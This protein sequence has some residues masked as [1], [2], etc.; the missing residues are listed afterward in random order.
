M[1]LR[2][3]QYFIQLCKDRNITKA[4][5]NLYISQQGLSK[6]I[7]RLEEEL[8]FP[9]FE[10]SASGVVPTE[11]ANYLYDYFYR[12]SNTFHELEL[13]IEH[14]R[15]NRIVNITAFCGF[16]LSCDMDVFSGYKR[17]HSDTR[18]HYEETDN[19]SIPDHL[20]NRKADIAFMAAPIPKGLVS[21]QIVC[22]EPVFA[23]MN[24][25]HPL[26]SRS[27]ISI[28]DLQGQQLLFLEML[29]MFREQFIMAAD[30][31]NLS[32]EIYG[33]ANINEFLP[34]LCTSNLIGFSGKNLYRHFDFT[35]LAFIPITPTDGLISTTETHLVT[36]QDMTPDTDLQSY[37]D[38][39]QSQFD[40]DCPVKS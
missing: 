11:A 28:Q 38:Y 7:N 34:L 18:I 40:T 39:V 13:A 12:T 14:V 23:V 9:L 36:L 32:Y 33:T 21:H 4:S 10:R 17:R 22:Q 20:Q 6:S 31:M 16:A 29:E 37:I 8:G 5:R 30:T 25:K 1:E 26:A 19:I 3:I 35:D 27:S 2:Q 15:H 24:Q